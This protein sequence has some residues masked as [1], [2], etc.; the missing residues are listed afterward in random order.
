MKYNPIYL[1]ISLAV[2]FGYLAFLVFTKT[3]ETEK[4]L[5]FRYSAFNSLLSEIVP[6]LELPRGLF[7]GLSMIFFIITGTILSIGSIACFLNIQI[8]VLFYS[9]FV[10]LIGGFIHLPFDNQMLIPQLRKLIFVIVIFLCLFSLVLWDLYDIDEL[11]KNIE[12]Q[13][14]KDKAKEKEKEK[15]KVTEKAKKKTK[16][17]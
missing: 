7:S 2:L 5:S 11:K 17:E 6:D 1:R 13:K 9:H 16:K 10:L 4:Y 8:L 3:K 14:A 12:R 15:E